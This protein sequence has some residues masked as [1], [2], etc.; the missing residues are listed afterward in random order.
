M[1]GPRRA[2]RPPMGPLRLDRA[3]RAAEAANA[4]NANQKKAVAAWA[5]RQRFSRLKPPLVI[6]L[7]AV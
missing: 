6:Q 7:L 4:A 2:P 1:T 5:S 3:D